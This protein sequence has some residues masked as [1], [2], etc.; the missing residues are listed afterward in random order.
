M[1]VKYKLLEVLQRTG[2]PIFRPDGRL[3]RQ[4][5]VMLSYSPTEVPRGRAEADA[6]LGT[7]FGFVKFVL[8]GQQAAASG[9]Y[10]P[11]DAVR[12]M[13]ANPEAGPAGGTVHYVFRRPY[14]DGETFSRL[15]RDRWV[16]SSGSATQLLLRVL[17]VLPTRERR[18]L[19]LAVEETL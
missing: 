1:L 2:E 16:G 9:R 7:D 5:D 13:L 11:A 19:T 12:R 17:G 3:D 15:V 6:R 14:L 10:L 8:P 4:V 18:P